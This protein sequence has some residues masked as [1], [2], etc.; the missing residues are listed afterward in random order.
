MP[1]KK[2]RL[3]SRTVDRETK[4]VKA[5]IDAGKLPRPVGMVF[6]LR[7]EQEKYFASWPPPK[8]NPMLSHLRESGVNTER[9]LRILREEALP[10]VISVSLMRIGYARH[11]QQRQK[12]IVALNKSYEGLDRRIRKDPALSDALKRTWSQEYDDIERTL[13]F[14]KG[15]PTQDFYLSREDGYTVGL[16]KDASRQ[17]FW[18]PVVVSLVN[19]WKEVGLTESFAFR[20][21]AQ[22]LSLAFDY[23][24]EPALVK[25]RYLHAQNRAAR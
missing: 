16:E 9:V 19:E 22:L 2:P 15:E 21:I 1:R 17:H 4:L 7:R 18:T 12:S 6:Q 10:K 5:W 23:P 8:M 14:L 3:R 13:R 20:D 24:D 11:F 25:R